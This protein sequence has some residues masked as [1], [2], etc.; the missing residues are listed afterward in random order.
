MVA[1]LPLLGAAAAEPAPAQEP[2]V[3]QAPLSVLEGAYTAEQAGRGETTFGR[4]CAEC[5]PP[6]TL[7]GTGF[8]R[9]WSGT[10]R[11]LFEFVDATMPEDNPGGLSRLAYAEVLAYIFQLNGYPPGE[12]E[13]PSDD[14]RLGLVV[15]EPKP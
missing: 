1:M 12:R 7:S 14:A 10:A 6:A 11:S 13:L 4:S 15:I 8:Q 3:Q 9:N 2:T 5:H